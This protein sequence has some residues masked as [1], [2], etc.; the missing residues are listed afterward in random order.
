[1]R[2]KLPQP[3]LATVKEENVTI[4]PTRGEGSTGRIQGTASGS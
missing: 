1:M 3:V 2:T 4:T